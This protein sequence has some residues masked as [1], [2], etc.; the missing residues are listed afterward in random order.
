MQPGSSKDTRPV[1]PPP[2]QE[3]T[4]KAYKLLEDKEKG[5][6]ANIKRY[7]G[8]VPGNPSYDVVKVSDPRP[9]YDIYHRLPT[10]LDLPIPHFTIDDNYTGIPPKREVSVFNLN[11]NVNAAFL[12]N[13]ACKIGEVEQVEVYFHPDKHKHLQMAMINFLDERDALSFVR[14][15]DG[16]SVMGIS[17]TCVSDPFYALLSRRYEDSVGKKCPIPNHLKSLSAHVLEGRRLKI[18]LDNEDERAIHVP[19]F[20]RSFSMSLESQDSPAFVPIRQKLPRTPS[21]PPV[22]IPRP[23]FATF[24]HTQEE[25]KPALVQNV[26]RES[27]SS[28]IEERKEYHKPP[29]YNTLPPIGFNQ[30]AE[31]PPPYDGDDFSKQSIPSTSDNREK[32]RDSRQK[33]RS[34]RSSTSDSNSSSSDS[35]SDS[36]YLTVEKKEKSLKYTC[37]K[38]GQILEKKVK[39]ITYKRKEARKSDTKSSGLQNISSDEA[40]DRDEVKE[41]RKQDH[42]WSS[43]SSESEDERKIRRHELSRKK[44]REVTKL[45]SFDMGSSHETAISRTSSV[46]DVHVS[47]IIPPV[48]MQPPPHPMI[49]VFNPNQPPPMI[50]FH[51]PPPVLNQYSTP[52]PMFNPVPTAQPLPTVELR[53]FDSP[54]REKPSLEDRLASLFGSTLDDGDDMP[55]ET[56]MNTEL[57]VNNQVEDMDVDVDSDRSPAYVA[58]PVCEEEEEDGKPELY[59][60]TMET[61]YH[62]IVADIRSDLCDV[63]IKDLQNRLQTHAFQLLE[64]R[65]Q[66]RRS[67]LEVEKKN[68]AIAALRASQD[69]STFK[70]SLEFKMLPSFSIPKKF[71]YHKKEQVEPIA[72]PSTSQLSGESSSSDHEE[73]SKS[74]SDPVAKKGKKEVISSSS[75]D[76]EVAEVVEKPKMFGLVRESSDSDME[77]TTNTEVLE[78]RLAMRDPLNAPYFPWPASTVN[79]DALP[80]PSE[81]FQRRD[82]HVTLTEH[83]YHKINRLVPKREYTEEPDDSSRIPPKKPSKIS[84]PFKPSKKIT[85][86]EQL[87]K[88][89]FPPRTDEEKR[90]IIYEWDGCFDA[91]DQKFLE[92]ALSQLQPEHGPPPPWKRRVPFIPTICSSA[93]DDDKSQDFE[94]SYEKFLPNTKGC[95]RAM[96]YFKLSLKQKRSLI[97][98]PEEFRQ[99][100]T[101]ISE[102][103][104]ATARHQAHQNK[105]SRILHRRLLTT[106]GDDKNAEFFKVNQLKY[107]KKVI[108]FARS[109][110]H[111][112]GLY[113]LEPIAPDDMIIEYVGQKIRSIV[114][115]EREI[116]YVRRGIGSSYM[117][118]IDE[119]C[120]IDATQRGNF[121]RF[122]NHS[123]LPNCYARILTVEGDKRIVIYSKTLI[124]KG[125]EITYDYKFPLEDDKIDCLCNA[126]TCRGT[127]N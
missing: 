26:Q 126:P 7:D 86:D 13:M 87:K 27:I 69:S 1:H 29:P 103:D 42:R 66:S 102:R 125:D 100:T 28:T 84:R 55:L 78:A 68:Q 72:T 79:Y 25:P 20:E 67:A 32:G 5:G 30:Y 82:Y 71:T 118:R 101:N 121:A 53:L 65:W 47:A 40:S 123:C 122:I 119:N 50:P 95:A 98:M 113:A 114:A 15:F 21:P 14:Q 54:P 92:M 57:P 48:V 39:T 38:E 9:K 18:I 116:Q 111:G 105:E 3:R 64:Q 62:A 107:R 89:T 117:F 73:N 104:E 108:K 74:D 75:S 76:E 46:S 97:R 8:R 96:G 22:P 2:R 109:R 37:A 59:K 43:S 93:Q 60:C 52:P 88:I 120:V 115:D 49:P 85:R 45:S 110:I 12:R 41:K 77:L 11:D 17:I 94:E 81:V 80:E 34:R 19:A 51:L 6:A 58:A 44:R 112:W 63:L 83:C 33:R 35:S 124:N 16:K 56:T 90:K 106:M 127:L 23:T 99:E 31:P 61:I 4:F 91:E 10:T 70:P 24:E 36:T